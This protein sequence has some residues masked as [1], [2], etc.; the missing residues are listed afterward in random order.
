MK[1]FTWSWSKLKNY[2]TCPKR[3]YEVDIIKRFSD[4]ENDAVKWGHTVHEAMANYIGKGM[5]LPQTVS[6]YHAWPDNVIQMRDEDDTIKVSVENKLAIGKDFSA[7]GYFDP[8]TWFRS[9]ADV[10]ILSPAGAITLD[11]KTG[12]KVN[13]EFEQLGLSSQCVF[14]H[15]PKVET[16]ES[17]YI[18]L[19]HD[20]HTHK[21]YRRDDMA[22]LWN[23][24]W[25]EIL[26]MDEAYRTTTYPAKPSGLC[27]RHCP[28]V[29]CPY[30]GKGSR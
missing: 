1:P 12:N 11:W 7:T 28:V 25:P 17:Y 10:M 26:Q 19:G 15:Y 30:Y 23:D 5:K 13:P 2:R 16:V 20:T 8:T 4:D 22:S 3:H 21:T 9:V 14:A 18:W 29:D 6:R 24:L 27:V